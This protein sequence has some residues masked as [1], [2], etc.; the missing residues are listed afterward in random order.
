[1]WMLVLALLQEEPLRY[2]TEKGAKRDLSVEISLGLKMSGNPT[3]VDYFRSASPFLSFEKIRIR[4]DARWSVLE[5]GRSRLEYREAR[6]D[7]RYDDEDYEY[8]FSAERP[9]GDLEKN[10]LKQMLWYVFAGGKTYRQSPIGQV[11]TEDKD[12]DATGEVLDHFTL[13]DVRLADHP[14]RAGGE[15]ERT[16]RTK[17]LQ[18]DNG[19]RFEIVQKS[20][21]EKLEG[22]RAH[23]VSRV[24]GTLV[25]PKEAKRDPNV[26]KSETGVEGTI[27][28]VLD[29]ARGEVVS[30]E[31]SGRV[32]FYYRASDPNGGDDHE[33]ELVL[34]V[35]S[36]IESR[37]P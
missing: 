9:P 31:S 3:T 26:L 35:E 18:K 12:Q 20:R 19:G 22:G 1:M 21:L 32:R 6:V 11:E 10:K 17:R 24:T 23:L 4:G 5:P 29:V 14:V 8:D 34:S 13:G 30:N 25:L 36:R 33:L 7:G 27:R 37:K 2:R 16:F 15:W 28:L